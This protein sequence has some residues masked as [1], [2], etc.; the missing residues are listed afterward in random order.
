MIIMD[1]KQTRG[2]QKIVCPLL[3]PKDLNFPVFLQYINLGFVISKK[4]TNRI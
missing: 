1:T 4:T 2:K 3:E